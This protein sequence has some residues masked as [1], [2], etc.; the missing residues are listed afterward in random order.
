MRMYLERKKA[1]LKNDHYGT[2][3]VIQWIGVCLPMQEAGL[4]SL[5]QELRSCMPSHVMKC[6][7]THKKKT[8]RRSSRFYNKGNKTFHYQ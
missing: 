7:H 2:S 4:P 8:E 6:G 5:V 3:L 1:I